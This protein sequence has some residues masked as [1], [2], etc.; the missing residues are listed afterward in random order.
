M[1]AVKPLPDRPTDTHDPHARGLQ[2]FQERSYLPAVSLTGP[3]YSSSSPENMSPNLLPRLK[4][5][6]SSDDTPMPP[7]AQGPLLTHTRAPKS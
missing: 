4:G 7:P 6:V 2:Q 3:Q 1:K 5:P